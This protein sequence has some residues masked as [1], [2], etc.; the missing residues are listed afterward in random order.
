M[1]VDVS[2]IVYLSGGV[3]LQHTTVSRVSFVGFA[4]GLAALN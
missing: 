2:M 3:E 1:C 4:N